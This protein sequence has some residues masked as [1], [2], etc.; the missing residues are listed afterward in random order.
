MDTP[1]PHKSNILRRTLAGNFIDL[2]GLPV[3]LKILTIGGYL[4]VFGM[5]F[6]TLVVEL[7]GERL[8][9]VRYELAGQNLQTPAIVM[10]ISGLAFILGWAYLLTDKLIFE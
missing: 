4:A 3:S 8:P 10:A 9:T 6:F 1:N 5:L 7:A 2:Q